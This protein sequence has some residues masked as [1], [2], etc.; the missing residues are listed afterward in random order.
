MTTLQS[1]GSIGL[2]ELEIMAFAI[3]V[4][5]P[6]PMTRFT[7]GRGRSLIKEYFCTYLETNLNSVYIKG[8]G[9]MEKNEILFF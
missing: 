1:L 3:S 7:N 2:M 5:I 8:L 6:I 4:P 9:S